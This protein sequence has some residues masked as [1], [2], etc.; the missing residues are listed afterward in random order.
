MAHP[1][2]GCQSSARFNRHDPLG[3]RFAKGHINASQLPHKV[4]TSQ[5][6]YLKHP[7]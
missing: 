7:S 4:H 3:L 6:V 5:S 2:W 1:W